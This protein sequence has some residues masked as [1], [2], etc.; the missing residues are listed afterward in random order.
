MHIF[1]TTW[2]TIF[3]YKIDSKSKAT[4][5]LNLCCRS[6]CIYYYDFA[7]VYSC[8][9]ILRKKYFL[10]L[11]ARL[12]FFARKVYLVPSVLTCGSDAMGIIF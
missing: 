1:F 3:F 7:W 12:K 2:V 9:E 8:S 11:M 5:W 4:A 10:R 6:F